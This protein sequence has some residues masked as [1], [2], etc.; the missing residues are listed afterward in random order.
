MDSL[1][2]GGAGFIGSHLA[3]SLVAQNEFVGIIDNLFRGSLSNLDTLSDTEMEFFN[4][5]LADYKNFETLVNLLERYRPKKIFHY[6]AI[7]GTQHFYDHPEL[8]QK[9]NSLAT[10]MLVEAIKKV[11]SVYDAPYL[12]FA[13]TS[14]NYG[15]PLVVPTSE[16]D[17]TY[18]NIE[19]VRDSYA[20]AKLMSEFYVRYGALGD[21]YQYLILRIFN[22]YGPNM[23]G[24][25]YGQVIP[26]FIARASGGEYPLK[27]IGDGTQTRSFCFIEDHINLTLKLINSKRAENSVVNLGNPTEISIKELA[28]KV[29]NHLGIEPL[30][31][32]TDQRAFDTQRRC[33]DLSYMLSLVGD[34]QFIDLDTGLEKM[35]NAMKRKND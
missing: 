22:V 10:L 24:T 2:T 3:K 17:T 28:V 15:D 27:I 32:F 23:V 30:L 34:Y 33:P 6:A 35:L 13:S 21:H 8:T 18:V 5:D 4:F 19:S 26:E 31:V 16:T 14:E 12:I 7:N 9:T 1:I 25:K 11:Y 20:A 29:L